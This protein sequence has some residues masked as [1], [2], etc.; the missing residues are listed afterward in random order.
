MLNLGFP[1]IDQGKNNGGHAAKV[2]SPGKHKVVNLI[3]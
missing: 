3:G 2:F 1:L